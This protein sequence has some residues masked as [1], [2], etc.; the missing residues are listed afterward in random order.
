MDQLASGE[1]IQYHQN[2]LITGPTGAGKSFLACALAHLACRQGYRVLYYYVPKLFRELQIAQVDG[3]LSRVLKKLAKV[4]LLVVDDWGLT[5]LKPD[6]YR[7]FLEILDD[8][9]GTGATLIT[10]Q[11]PIATWHQLVEDPTVGDAILDRLVHN[12][13]K[14]ELKGES[15]REKSTQKKEK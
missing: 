13:H 7:L 11:Y 10:S 12:A 5:T 4:D 8:R 3:S 15:M 1:W 14:I 2:C 6:Q 9:Q